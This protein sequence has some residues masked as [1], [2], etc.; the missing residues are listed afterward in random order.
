MPEEQAFCVLVKIMFNYKM[1]DMFKNGFEE[2]H[3]NFYIL[4]R[5][6]EVSLMCH[7]IRAFFS[8]S[9]IRT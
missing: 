3:L 1:R 6:I 2:L 7:V 5:L 4:D 9:I 8:F